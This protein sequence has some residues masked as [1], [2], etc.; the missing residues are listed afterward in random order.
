M[1][2]RSFST[3]FAGTLCRV[4]GNPGTLTYVAEAALR[5]S[6]PLTLFRQ[7]M[8]EKSGS[9]KGKL[10]IKANGTFMI[11]NLVRVFALLHGVAE[12]NTWERIIA[13]R[14][15]EAF[16]PEEAESITEALNHLVELRLKNMV[17]VLLEGGEPDSFL[18]P[19]ELSPWSQ[20][21]LKEAYEVIGRLH[22]KAREAFYWLR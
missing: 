13:L 14:E 3:D 19:H 9:R 18:D 6:P 20:R 5:Q 17:K 7:F 16:T 21:M 2:T 12:T 15:R 11:I 22:K 1:A 4:S 10:N 8:V